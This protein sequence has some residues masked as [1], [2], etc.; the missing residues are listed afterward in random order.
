MRRVFL[1]PNV[2][3]SI[4]MFL[5]Y[6]FKTCDPLETFIVPPAAV[7]VYLFTGFLLLSLSLSLFP[8]SLCSQKP[9]WEETHITE[10]WQHPNVVGK[11]RITSSAFSQFLLPLFLLVVV[12]GSCFNFAVFQWLFV[13]PIVQYDHKRDHKTLCLQSILHTWNR[14]VSPIR[15]NS[16]LSISYLAII[17]F[18]LN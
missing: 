5:Q 1:T 16:N 17:W 6:S 7:C 4:Y 15:T 9:I 18:F 8:V 13:K 11:Y 14:Y 12:S 3:S 10:E 2:R